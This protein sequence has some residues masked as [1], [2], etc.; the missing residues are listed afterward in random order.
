MVHSQISLKHFSIVSED[1]EAKADLWLCSVSKEVLR[2]TAKL[3]K[4]VLK[5]SSRAGRELDPL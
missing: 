3:R 5:S 1:T 2:S 4:E